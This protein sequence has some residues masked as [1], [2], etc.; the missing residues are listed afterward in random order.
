MKVT[1]NTVYPMMIGTTHIDAGSTEDVADWD[2]VKDSYPVKT[3]LEANAISVEAEKAT[4]AKPL[5]KD[6]V[7]AALK[8]LGQEADARK[9]VADLTAQLETAKAKA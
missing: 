2:Q 5:T 1:N 6:Q 9:S 8:D 4:T 3:F 7:L